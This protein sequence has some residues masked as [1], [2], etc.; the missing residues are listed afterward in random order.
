ANVPL[1]VQRVCIQVPAGIRLLTGIRGTH[2]HIDAFG[3]QETD[4]FLGYGRTPGR[5]LP[6]SAAL[7]ELLQAILCTGDQST[8]RPHT[9]TVGNELSYFHRQCGEYPG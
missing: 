9:G 6:P 2:H 3:W 5:A 7:V 8:H 1:P 4:R